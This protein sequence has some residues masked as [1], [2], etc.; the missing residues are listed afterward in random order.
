[1]HTQR[2][3]VF[4]LAVLLGALSSFLA[5]AHAAVSVQLVEAGPRSTLLRIIVDSPKLEDVDTPAGK[6]Q[7]FSQREGGQG[8]SRLGDGS[9]GQPE[10][11]VIGFPLA[12]PLDLK[13]VDV[14]V[15]PEGEPSSQ[16]AAIYP[17]QPMEIA[18]KQD[19]E[20]PKFQFDPDTYR[21]GLRLPGEALERT[22]IF[23]GDANVAT[24]K[25]S[26]FGYDPVKGVLSFYRS[27]LVTVLH[28]AG[29]CFVIDRLVDTKTLPAF[30]GIDRHFERL[31]LP[32]LPFALNKTFALRQFCPPVLVPNVNLF[33][34]RFLIVTHPNFVA[35]ANTLRAHKVAQGISTLVV[36]TQTITGGP[37]AASAVQIRN[38]IANY[39][40]THLIKP[41]WV[42]FMGD[43]EYVPTHYD[44]NNTY[45]LA[46]NASDIWYGQ[47]GAGPTDI[48]PFG[49]GR[50]PVD[51]LA[52][53]NTIV[54]KVMAFETAPPSNP[55]FGSDFY[56]RL[57]FASYFQGS[58]PTDDRWFAETS[59][60][61]RDYT[62]TLG[63][64]PR[65]I[66]NASAAAN[67]LFYRG[68][69]AIPPDLRKP[70][71]A[72]N[73]STADIVDA[74]NDGTALLYH[75]D[76]GWWDGWGDP[77]FDTGDLAAIAV[78][79]NQFPVVFSINCASGIFDNETVDLP[80]NIVGGGYGPGAGS[81]YW[82]EAFLRKSD[83]ALAVIGD[84][85]SS[86]TIDNNHLTLGLFD[87]IF[88][89]FIPG[90]GGASP[91]LRL[92]DV[93]NH[94]KAFIAA[95]DS[96]ATPNL[97]PF[98]AGGVRPGVWGLR[99]ELNLY[100]LLG[101]PTVKLR[102]S[103]P[104]RFAVLDIAVLEGIAVL[105]LPI[106]EPPCRGCPFP[107]LITAVAID[108]KTGRAI[109]RTLIDDKGNGEI[110]LG[111]FKGNFWVRVGSPDGISTQ[112]ALDETDTDRDGVPDSRDNCINVANPGQ[113]DSD[114]DGYG[115]VCDGD[116]NNDGIVNS[117]D[118]AQFRARFGTRGD[119]A[120]DFNGDNVVNAL[121]L[122]KFRAL[123]ATRPGPSAWHLPAD[124][125]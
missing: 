29:D 106:P 115:N 44:L 105:K 90:Y 92:G 68:G 24:F 78:T 35:A 4:S 85:R 38:W 19:R 124:G 31:P 89:G 57:T 54:S 16:N 22:S 65:R 9:V 8:G 118:L 88:P 110:D 98:D 5:M 72:W 17:V 58:D 119:S 2:H 59:E 33:G 76:H 53:A 52:Q 125:G 84:T 14:E 95:V 56:N 7:R 101:D 46:K 30:D 13:G 63:Y 27:Y 55:L 104:W 48:P 91:I 114:G 23:K 20:L 41:K 32:A 10:L 64:S 3:S 26:P 42:L 21:K 66:Y 117:I 83:G 112:A 103:P 37:A 111:G 108:P 67:P 102:V 77:P 79:N 51:T 49:I 99:Q 81:V 1:M 39:Y 12:L 75:R 40:A 93:L 11:P 94:A 36:S 113:I 47:F 70:G 45:D 15:K 61:V 87:A 62:E 122:A 50:F 86:S 116:L 6:F 69:G 28:P 121:D 96:G 109:G 60:L 43:A 25:F 80:A 73:G 71:F 82:A 18:R 34:A 74:V 100:N 97:H 107:E 123:F 120:A